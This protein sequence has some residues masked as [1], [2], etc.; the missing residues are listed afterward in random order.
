MNVL[1]ALGIAALLLAA[2]L[3]GLLHALGERPARVPPARPRA[4]FRE[5]L[6]QTGDDV[7]TNVFRDGS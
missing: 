1:P 6:E 2:I 7:E 5:A 3:I 4:T